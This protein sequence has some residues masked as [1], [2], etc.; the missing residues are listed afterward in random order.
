MISK[1]KALVPKPIKAVF[2]AVIDYAVHAPAI[3]RLRIRRQK[4]FAINLISR[5]RRIMFVSDA[6]TWREMKLAHGLKRAGWDVTLLYR[7]CA[8][9]L[10]LKSFH[11]VIQFRSSWDALEQA[12]QAST[13][14]FHHFAYC[15]D[16]TSVRL[17]QNKPGRVIFDF[18]DNIFS[19]E[20]GLEPSE[21]KRIQIAAQSFCIENADA[22]CC[23][24]MQLQYRRKETK[25]GQGKPLILFPE[26][27]WNDGPLPERR[28]DGEIHIAQVGWMGLETLGQADVGGYRIFEKFVNAGC[29]LHIYLHPVYPAFGSAAFEAAF[30]NY[31]ELGRKTGRVHIYPTVSPEK[32][33]AE[34]GKYDFGAGV[35]NGLTFDISWLNHNPARFPFCGSSRMF[36][37]LDAG[38]GMI[39]H[40]ELQFMYRTFRPYGVAFDTS[41]LLETADPKAALAS[42]P[43]R[44]AFARARKALS[45]DQHISRLT[46][47]Y[48]NLA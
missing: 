41:R 37:Y 24:D 23:R 8:P 16:R 1:L 17:M 20:D 36:D 34:L 9:H 29:H 6:P 39:L 2:K 25:L 33:I 45:I 48:E 38:L 15:G 35:T 43:D 46:Q 31:L 30:A 42:R 44:D 32:L 26:Y 5:D 28:G 12:H 22:L 27:C 10:D 3:I 19:M 40:E 21:P 47:F 7:K 13:R 14:V 11:D 4:Q 18:Y